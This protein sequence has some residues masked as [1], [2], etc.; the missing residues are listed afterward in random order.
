MPDSHGL[1][2]CFCGIARVRT[3]LSSSDIIITVQVSDEAR[4]RLAVVASFVFLRNRRASFF[5]LNR[6]I[7]VPRTWLPSSGD[8]IACLRGRGSICISRAAGFTGY[9]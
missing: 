9:S 2:F 7:S 1:V 5:V 4:A 8:I 3:W 6:T